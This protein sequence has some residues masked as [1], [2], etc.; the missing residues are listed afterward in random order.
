[1]T[2]NRMEVLLTVSRLQARIS[3]VF[4]SYTGSSVARFSILYALSDSDSLSQTDLRRLLGINASAVTRHVQHLEGSGLVT[5]ERI[6]GDQRNVA[7]S[8]TPAGMQLL[9]G[10]ENNRE[11]FLST[12]FAGLSH[13]ELTTLLDIVSSMES[14]LDRATELCVRK[15]STIADNG[16]TDDK[17][18]L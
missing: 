2:D 18:T 14:H 15:D 12:L 6:P 16:S 1:M 17:E 13:G 7:V 5:R 11:S 8:I 3:N 4:E 9:K 10:C